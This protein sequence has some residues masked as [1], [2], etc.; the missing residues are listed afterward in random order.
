MI[1]KILNPVTATIVAVFI[2]IAV[3]LAWYQV[4]A[5]PILS[6]IAPRPAAGAAAEAAQKEKGWDFWTIEVENLSGELKGEKERLRAEAEQLDL[7]AQRLA[8][9]EQ[10]LKKVRMNLESMR[11][12]INDRVVEISADES[13]NLRTLSQMYSNLT[14]KAAVAIIQ[15]MD[16]TTAIKI[17]SLMKPDIVGPIF[18]TMAQNGQTDARRA[19]ALSDRLRLLK[20]P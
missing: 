5:R 14:P 8:S 19:A 11:K 9:E 1:A 7:K 13:K 6:A 15:E 3:G 18:E 12:E 4:K 17:L 16:D 2:G 20:S 10:E